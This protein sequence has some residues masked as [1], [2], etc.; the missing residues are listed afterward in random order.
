MTHGIVPDQ[1]K[2][3]HVIPV[4][5]S[6]DH[7]QFNNYRWISILPAF[8]K[9]LERIIY[10]RLLEYIDKYNILCD[11]HY[12]FKKAH[13]T[14]VA[15]KLSSAIDHRKFTIGIFFDLSKAFDTVNHIR[16]TT[17]EHCGF[18]GLVFHWIKTYFS[19]RKQFTQYNGHCSEFDSGPF[20]LFTIY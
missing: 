12:G 10:N 2:I 7:S 13:S 6:D 18:R 16:F 9:F 1:M 17:L 4:Y 11:Q 5:K 15:L 20:V 14:S 8:S 19:N 3:A